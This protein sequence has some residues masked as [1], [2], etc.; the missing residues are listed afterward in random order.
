M[1]SSNPYALKIDTVFFSCYHNY[2]PLKRF[3]DMVS[4]HVL[5][6]GAGLSNSLF[7]PTESILMA[8]LKQSQRT[9]KTLVETYIELYHRTNAQLDPQVTEQLNN[10]SAVKSI[11]KVVDGFLKRLEN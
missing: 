5:N 3:T 7:A 6:A 10:W 11:K 2:A 8:L 4:Q 9:A 1:V